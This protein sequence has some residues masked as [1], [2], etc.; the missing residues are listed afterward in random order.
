MST[1]N[2]STPAAPAEAPDKGVGCDAL[3][4]VR[5]SAWEWHHFLSEIED[6]ILCVANRDQ[7]NARI[8][9]AKI[10]TQLAGHEV[11]M[12][13]QK[14]PAPLDDDRPEEKPTTLLKRVFG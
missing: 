8:L 14:R 7:T 12:P 6:G 2:V 10:A 1:E 13:P 5:L 9:Y 11:T 4:A 3:L